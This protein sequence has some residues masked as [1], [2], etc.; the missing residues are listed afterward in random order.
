MRRLVVL[1]GDKQF[2]FLLAAEDD[3]VEIHWGLKRVDLAVAVHDLQVLPKGTQ[4]LIVL[5]DEVD[6]LVVDGTVHDTLGC[7]E[8]PVNEEVTKC[9]TSHYNELIGADWV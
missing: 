9:S 6:S 2:P 5:P 8:A 1:C 3:E 4:D 7:K